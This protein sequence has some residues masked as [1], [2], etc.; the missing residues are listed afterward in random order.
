MGDPE[1]KVLEAGLQPLV[2]RLRTQAS[3][4]GRALDLARISADPAAPLVQ[5]CE[6]PR[7]LIRGADRVPHLRVLRD[8]TQH[9]LLD[10][11]SDKDRH[12]PR[13]PRPQLL[14]P[15]LATRQRLTEP[16]YTSEGP[17]GR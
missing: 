14:A 1:H 8:Q 7:V 15:P 4:V 16:A 3:D 17:A 9:Y 5:H 10:S 11:P 6:L 12:R 2:N 13:T